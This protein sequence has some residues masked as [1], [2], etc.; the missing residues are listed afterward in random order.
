MTSMSCFLLSL[1][2]SHDAG[3]PNQFLLC[4]CALAFGFPAG[5]SLWFT[6]E[7]PAR[8]QLLLEVGARVSP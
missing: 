1:E 5:A 6:V 8:R 7:Y 3:I 4:E 2:P